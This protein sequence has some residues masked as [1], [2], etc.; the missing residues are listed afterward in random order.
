MDNTL[1]KDGL[2]NHERINK[3][4]LIPIANNLI[5]FTKE[6]NTDHGRW[7]NVDFG[8]QIE[9]YLKQFNIINEAKSLL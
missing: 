8:S 3:D 7:K 2:N 5:K 1:I 4:L 9:I 6:V